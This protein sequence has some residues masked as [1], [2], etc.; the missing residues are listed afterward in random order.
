MKDFGNTSVKF[1]KIFLRLFVAQ[2]HP[3]EQQR[4]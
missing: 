4:L 2:F 1:R 3:Q